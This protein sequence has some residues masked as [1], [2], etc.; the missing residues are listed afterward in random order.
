ML[1]RS[2]FMTEH[3]PTRPDEPPLA[4]PSSA[5]GPGPSVPDGPG[6]PDGPPPPPPLSAVPTASVTG[7]GQAPAT[8]G[9]AVAVEQTS[10][11][12]RG[13]CAALRCGRAVR[14]TRPVP[15]GERDD[16]CERE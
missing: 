7:D 15:L 16:A 9:R 6:V 3:D 12:D 13:C 1:T 10:W 5:A 8:K 14:R 4:Q 2:A 11:M